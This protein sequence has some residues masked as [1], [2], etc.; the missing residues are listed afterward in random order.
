VNRFPWES[1][2]EDGVAFVLKSNATKMRSPATVLL[3]KARDKELEDPEAA[4][5]TVCT[6]EVAAWASWK[7]IKLKTRKSI[8]AI[9]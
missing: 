6:Y 5:A 2:T 8:R 1:V 4:L 7:I 3:G 9:G